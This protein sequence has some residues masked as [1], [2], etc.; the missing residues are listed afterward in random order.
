MQKECKKNAKR[1]QNKCDKEKLAV[2]KL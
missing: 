1:M 2:W